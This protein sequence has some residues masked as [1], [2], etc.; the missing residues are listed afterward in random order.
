MTSVLEKPM[1]QPKVAVDLDGVLTEH[2]TLL[3]REA[4]R[5]FKLDLPDTAFVDSA[6]HNIS[7]EVRSWVYGPDGPASR[8]A[9]A[10]QAADFLQELVRTFG[11]ENVYI[12]TARPEASTE[13][14]NAWLQANGLDLCNVVYADDK[15][16]A[17]SELGI[18]HAI[19]DSVRHATSYTEAGVTAYL[20]TGE[21]D[22]VPEGPQA[23]T[24]LAEI[25]EHLKTLAG[26]DLPQ[27]G[28]R[29]RVVISDVIDPD[30]HEAIARATDV[31]DVDGTDVAALREAVAEA[32]ALVIRSE[33]QVDE[34]LLRHARKLRV[35]ARAGVGVDNIDID[36]ATRAGILVLNAPGSNSISAGEH[37]I[38][39]MLALARQLTNANASM[40]ARKWERKKFKI[41]DLQGKT[42][43]IV[44]LGRVGGV[45]AER[46]KAFGVNLIA[47]DPYIPQERFKEFDVE[48][49]SYHELLSRSD[50]VTYH[51]PLTNETHHYLSD[52]TVEHLKPGA[53][54]INCARGEVVDH[55]A[56]ARGLDSGVIAAAGVDV[57]P[58]EPLPDS[59]LWDRPNVILTPHIGGSSVEAQ[60]AVG[61]I[62]SKS[63]LAALRG[64]AVPNTVNLP[65]VAIEPTISL[66]LSRVAGAA[67]RLLSTFESE[68]PSSFTMTVRGNVSEEIN[69]LILT[70]ALAEGLQQWASGRVTPVNARM[71]AREHEITVRLVHEKAADSDDGHVEFTFH[72]NEDS[73]RSVTMHWSGE[74]VGIYEINRFSLGQPL[75][76]DLLITRHHDG[77][78]VIGGIGTILGKYG[79]NIAGMQ[80]GRRYQGGE[81]LMI[82][83]VDDTIPEEARREILQLENS[84]NAYVVSLP[85][86]EESHMAT[87]D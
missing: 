23:V 44:G 21:L 1:T 28:E 70:S 29:P 45:V 5:R 57:F 50:I 37:T 42:V 76:G 31:H 55:Q 51:V 7:D 75:A 17:A 54:V 32:D 43:G 46:L 85:P 12:V 61:E 53:V 10:E 82:L 36:A 27:E 34:E 71:V 56:L 9:V 3:A 11:R 74:H 30:A 16:A 41:F 18:T 33:T 63:T 13:M 58:E 72:T 62:I 20:L 47:H 86:P 77:P 40:H 35:I 66:R 8:L 15:V 48:Q 67:G 80:V 14:T 22:T 4:N 68:N 24:D 60:A 52:E 84:F 73:K 2:P 38:S 6:G 59:P 79:V 49:V 65:A 87:A 19:E 39:I 78:G 69:E 81:A 26:G 25:S 83:N 64:E